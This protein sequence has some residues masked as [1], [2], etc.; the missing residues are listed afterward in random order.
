MK[1]RSFPTGRTLFP[2]VVAL[3]LLAGAQAEKESPAKPPAEESLSFPIM[4]WYGPGKEHTDLAH[5]REMANAGFTINL[6]RFD[7]ETNKKALGLAEK[8]GM[9][10]VIGD[11]RI[12][13]TKPVDEAALVVIDRVVDDY[14]DHP[15]LFGYYIQDE[16]SASLFENMA[17]IKERI[18]SRDPNHTVYANLLPNYA[19]EQQLGTPTYREHVE[20]WMQTFKP[21]VLSYDHYPFVTRSFRPSYYGNLD[22][23]RGAALRAKIPF[24]AFTMSC[25]INP[26]YPTPK[27]SWMRLQLYS[28]LA[29]GA[30]GLQYFTYGLHPGGGSEIFITAILDKEGKKTFLYD[31][32]KRIN[33][34]IHAL[35]PTLK[36][37]TSLDVFHTAPI[38]AGT[39]GLPKDFFVKEVSGGPMAI[40]YFKDANGEPYL[41]MVNRNYDA[42]V[43]FALS[44]TDEVSGLVEVSKIA[45]GKSESYEKKK[46]VVTLRFKEGDGRLFRARR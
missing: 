1:A 12:Q 31:I 29:Y 4:T 32:A 27:E 34:E 14:K 39:K 21:Q 8:V 17:K 44:L 10:V 43:D 45:K 26:G 3:L 6:C 35:A 24:W 25:E 19:R 33:A 9:K 46:G 40:G 22:V 30:Q 28:D 13:P 23:I 41:L 16:A 18:L 11:Y 37:L 42:P 7:V 38:P 36:G 5:F 2:A 15:A 20:K